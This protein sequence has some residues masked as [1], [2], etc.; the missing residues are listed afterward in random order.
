MTT[1]ECI[2]IQNCK[3]YKQL[4]K[5]NS[6]KNNKKSDLPKR[7]RGRPKCNKSLVM[8]EFV[9]F[10]DDDYAKFIPYILEYKKNNN[11]PLFSDIKIDDYLVNK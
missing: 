3:A 1:Y 2:I 6:K 4:V 9:V 7:K 8:Q 5:Y 10:S 11:L